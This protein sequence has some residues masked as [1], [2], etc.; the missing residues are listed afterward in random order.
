MGYD[1]EK[2]IQSA[3][4]GD[5]EKLLDIVNHFI[6]SVMA[7]DSENDYIIHKATHIVIC[8][9]APVDCFTEFTS[10]VIKFSI[11]MDKLEKFNSLADIKIINGISK[12]GYVK[13][14][15][16]AFI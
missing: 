12:N 8:V 11:Q 9:K 16:A 6:S 1:I 3:K 10:K 2:I 13:C 14:C 15:L 7:F 4:N 5:T